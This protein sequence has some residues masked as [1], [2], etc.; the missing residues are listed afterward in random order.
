MSTHFRPRQIDVRAQLQIITDPDLIEEIDNEIGLHS[1]TP[2]QSR[3]KRKVSKILHN[4]V[5]NT[6]K[7]KIKICSYQFPNFWRKSQVRSLTILNRL[8]NM[9]LKKSIQ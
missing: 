5:Q 7:K 8:K 9:K 4:I 6:T 2:I 3:K 1:F